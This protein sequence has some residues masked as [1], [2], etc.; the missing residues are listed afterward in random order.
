MKQC[1]HADAL[2][3]PEPG[4]LSDTCPGCLAE[5]SHPVQLRLCLSCGHV[6]CCDSSPG[7]HATEHFKESGHPVMRTFE[8]GENWRWCFVDHVLV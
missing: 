4:A 5:G 2:P 7:R 6:G 3:H 1:T 8:P